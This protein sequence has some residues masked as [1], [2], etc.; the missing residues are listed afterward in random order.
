[1]LDGKGG[2]HLQFSKNTVSEFV[3]VPILLNRDTPYL[4]LEFEG[5]QRILVI[6]SGSS[7]CL[8]HRVVSYVAWT[9]TSIK[10]F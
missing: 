6:V 8:L 5:V 1:M 10:Q 3:P 2:F 4:I 9:C 7:C